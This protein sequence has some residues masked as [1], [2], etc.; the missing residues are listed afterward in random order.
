MFKQS[1]S[2]L[3]ILSFH[4]CMAADLDTI[5]SP[6]IKN[7]VFYWAIYKLA[8]NEPLKT[9][10]EIGSSNGE[11]STEA[12]ALGIIQNPHNPILY[13]M[14]ISRIRFAALQRRYAQLPCV[15]CYNISSVPLSSFPSEQ[16]I[17]SFFITTP[18]NLNQYGLQTVLG[19]LDQDIE[20]LKNATVPQNGIEIIKRE[21]NIEHFD[22]VLIDGSEFTGKAEF[23]LI[24]GARFILLDDI[25]AFKNHENYVRLCNDP[26]YELIE[27]DKTLR[28]GY[29]IFRKRAF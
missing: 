1:L 9:I 8:K 19:W 7:D 13:C 2:L 4:A 12:F 18:T 22:M 11:G 28:N 21:N 24:Y 5:I 29:A 23:A 16:E 10:L 6:E 25:S 15:K 20:Y 17:S 14:E 27:E 3:L 26:N